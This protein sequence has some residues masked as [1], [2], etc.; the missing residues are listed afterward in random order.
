VLPA[1]QAFPLDPAFWRDR[2]V[3]I[4]G[5][6]GFKGSWLVLLLRALG[7]HVT[8]YSLPAPTQ[9]S[10]FGLAGLDR[11]PG[12][13]IGDVRDAPLLENTVH[14][15]HPEIIFHLAAQ[16]L[17]RRSLQQPVETWETNVMGTLYLLEAARRA[18]VP[19]VVVVTSDKCYETG[20]SGRP[21]REG[22]P[23]GGSDPYSGSKASVEILVDSWRQS[24]FAPSGHVT[25]VATV[26]GGN[27]LGG[28][29]FAEDRLVPD[30]VRGALRGEP[31]LLRNPGAVRPWQHV[32][33]V[34]TGYLLLAERLHR[35]RGEYAEAWN[36]GP[37]ADD[38]LT[39]GE[40]A[41]KVGEGWPDFPRRE[42]DSRTHPREN[43]WLMLDSTRARTRL[44]WV[45]RWT[46]E[47]SIS[48]TV[49]W[50][51]NWA[52]GGGSGAAAVDSTRA[53]FHDFGVPGD[54]F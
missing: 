14:S 50:Y 7:A 11:L 41:Q 19:A 35:N 26:R 4:T 31:V 38:L 20:V 1:G 54:P 46:V 29:D 8:G 52:E 27:V 16:S 9:P 33:D 45:P 2:R 6:T 10:L 30:L 23:L 48:R 42:S 32:L 44:G 21:F 40:V 49:R 3:L 15:S 22:D 53:D 37:S 25:A 18:E 47:E 12:S 13:G 34:L 39:V 24:F 17:V 51:R 36:F 43:Q 28:G 5:H